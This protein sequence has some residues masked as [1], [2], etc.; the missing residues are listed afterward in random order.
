MKIALTLLTL[1]ALAF[2]VQEISKAD[3][4]RHEIHECI[5]AQSTVDNFRGTTREAYETY[6]T[7]CTQ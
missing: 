2:Y 4:T 7:T 5:H 1:L 3:A 6:F